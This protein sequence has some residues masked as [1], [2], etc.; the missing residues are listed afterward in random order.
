MPAFLT[1]ETDWNVFWTTYTGRVRVVLDDTSVEY[2]EA[3][4]EVLAESGQEP[5]MAVAL[6]SGKEVWTHPRYVFPVQ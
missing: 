2:G 3:T 6:E 1:V 5:G 4:G